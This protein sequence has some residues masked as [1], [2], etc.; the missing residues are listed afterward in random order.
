MPQKGLGSLL[1]NLIQLVKENETPA[2][3][4]HRSGTLIAMALTK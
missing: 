4:S 2:A 1:F 3:S